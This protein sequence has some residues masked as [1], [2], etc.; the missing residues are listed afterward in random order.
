M[1]ME[2][3]KE[4]IK[5]ELFVHQKEGLGWL[6][7]R[8]N[9]K[10]LP[11]FWEEKNGIFFNFVMNYTMDNRPEPLRGRLF[12]DDMGLEEHIVPVMLKTFMYYGN[13][14][15]TDFE[16]IKKYDVVLTT[17]STLTMDSRSLNHVMN[18]EW[19]RV[20]LDV[21]HAIKNPNSKQSR[22]VTELKA[23]R[24]WVVTATEAKRVFEKRKNP[25]T[26]AVLLTRISIAN[27]PIHRQLNQPNMANFRL[28]T[29]TEGRL[30]E[31]R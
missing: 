4:I 20:I 13:N 31:F 12:A 25:S 6:F 1:A 28:F 18:T 7:Q 24:R 10:D 11:S 23:K 22:V 30:D 26:T 19:R 29:I 16:E 14:T 17:Y 2:P 9:S 8:E 21:A 15:T 27:P 5:S 3:P